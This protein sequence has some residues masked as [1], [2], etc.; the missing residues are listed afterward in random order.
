MKIMEYMTKNEKFRDSGGWM[1][2]ELTPAVVCSDGFRMSVQA[3]EYAYCYPRENTGPHYEFEVG[4]PSEKEELLMEWAETPEA[5][6]E[7]VYGYVP[8]DVIDEVIKKHGGFAK[9]S[10][11]S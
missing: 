1:I 5:P 8:A 10:E 9:N 2:K 6:T 7:T 11:E 3:S 4:F